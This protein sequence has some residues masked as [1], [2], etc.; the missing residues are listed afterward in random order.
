ME[1]S[2]RQKEH[3]PA[4]WMTTD[5]DIRAML[6]KYPHFVPI[7]NVMMRERNHLSYGESLILAEKRGFET[8]KD[9][10]GQERHVALLPETLTPKVIAKE[11]GKSVSLVHK[12]LKAM[13]DIGVLMRS[14]QTGPNAYSV[15]SI[16]YWV[17]WENR[18]RIMLYL[19][20]KLY[21]KKGPLYQELLSFNIEFNKNYIRRSS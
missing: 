8:H 1:E 4:K 10:N 19:Q 21:G 3:W 15:Y 13:I 16:G 6:H 14:R 11:I 20:E 7:L 5:K 2:V 12:Y 17:E 9:A 18:C